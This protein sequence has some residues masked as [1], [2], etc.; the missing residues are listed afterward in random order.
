MH[1]LR[2]TKR[3]WYSISPGRFHRAHRYLLPSP[4]SGRPGPGRSSRTPLR[5]GAQ[6]SRGSRSHGGQCGAYR[7]GR[8]AGIRI[9]KRSPGLIPAGFLPCAGTS[10]PLSRELLE[11]QLRKSGD[12]PFVIRDCSLTYS[13]TLFAP[14]GELNRMRREFLLRAEEALLA[15]SLPQKTILHGRDIS[16]L[17]HFRNI[18]QPQILIGIQAPRRLLWASW[19]MPIRWK[20]YPWQ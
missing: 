17:P 8:T 12:T 5:P 1:R 19:C 4:A 9:G 16:L 14:V 20:Q 11:T 7:N 2:R 15:S 3:P 18:P 10:R 13:G 6:G